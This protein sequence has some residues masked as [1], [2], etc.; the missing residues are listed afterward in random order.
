MWLK[1]N[2]SNHKFLI[3][4]SMLASAALNVLLYQPS[5]VAGASVG[6]NILYCVIMAGLT[7]LAACTFRIGRRKIEAYS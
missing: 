6:I 3:T 1:I 2:D 7:V 4:M 5:P